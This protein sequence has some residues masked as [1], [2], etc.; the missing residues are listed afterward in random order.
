MMKHIFWD[1]NGTILDDA[2]VTY[3]ILIKM[4]KE[5]NRPLVTFEEY[6]HIFEFPVIN[7]YEKVYDLNVSDFKDL[8]NRFINYYMAEYVDA[9]LHKDVLKVIEEFKNRGY[10]NYLLSASEINN[11][12]GQLKV[13]NLEN[14]FDA[15]LGINNIY[16][17]S[18][19]DV[20]LEFIKANEI[21]PKEAIMIGD[22][23]HDKE[24]ADALGIDIIIFTK[25]HQHKDRLKHLTNIDNIIELIDKI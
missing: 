7:Y 12:L 24:V 10:K 2:K 25:G 23:L 11:L 5:E 6:L 9:P 20:G 22:T 14:T 19:V 21:N 16:A 3:N 13:L 4:L 8:A 17:T 18:K 15:V 1:F